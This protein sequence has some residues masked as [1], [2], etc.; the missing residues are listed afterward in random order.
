[1]QFLRLSINP[2][3]SPRSNNKSTSTSKTADIVKQEGAGEE[4]E[5]FLYKAISQRSKHCKSNPKGPAWVLAVSRNFYD[6]IISTRDS[7]VKTEEGS[8]RIWCRYYICTLLPYDCPGSI[9][10]HDWFWHIQGSEFPLVRITLLYGSLWLLGLR[11][12]S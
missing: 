11:V 3:S 1:M 8:K 5:V 9:P 4:K 2:L 12:Q 10:G 6:G 7:F